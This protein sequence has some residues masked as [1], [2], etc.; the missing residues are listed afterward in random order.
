M[1]NAY[2]QSLPPEEYVSRLNE[3]MRNRQ[4]MFTAPPVEFEVQGAGLESRTQLFVPHLGQGAVREAIV[5][6]RQAGLLCFPPIN[7]LIERV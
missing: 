5:D 3:L 4:V 6:L 1:E 7:A 2:L